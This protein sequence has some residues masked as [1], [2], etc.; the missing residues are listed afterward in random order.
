MTVFLSGGA[1][2]GELRAVPSKSMAHRLFI[3]AASGTAPCEIACDPLA[4]DLGATLGCL[5][6]LGASVSHTDGRVR[7]EPI[8]CVPAGEVLLPCG[9]SGT[10][11]R[12][13]LPL[14]GSFG[15]SAVFERRG[16]LALRPL[17]PFVS[18]LKRHGMTI[19]NEGG[20][21]RCAGQLCGGE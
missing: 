15:T 9:E 6:A 10:T 1:R 17:E 5:R 7:I 8:R 11:L 14:A 16:R 20:V 18:E 3:L 19:G 12:F 13:F 2:H 4:S 21:L